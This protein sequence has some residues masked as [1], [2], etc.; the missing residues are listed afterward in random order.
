VDS[1]PFRVTGPDGSALALSYLA[2]ARKQGMALTPNEKAALEAETR[3]L[4]AELKRRYDERGIA[5]VPNAEFVDR[6]RGVRPEEPS[7]A[8]ELSDAERLSYR[9]MTRRHLEGTD[10][11]Y[12]GGI[13]WPIGRQITE[14]TWDKVFRRLDRGH[15]NE[16]E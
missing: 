14:A 16:P 9:D 13:A 11:S 3:A 10:I 7:G 4:I 8:P 6:W 1:E 2:L 5:G 12:R 15:H